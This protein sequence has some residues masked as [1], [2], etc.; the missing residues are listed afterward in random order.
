VLTAEKE[1][2][3]VRLWGIDAPE[4][5]QDFG[6]ASREALSDLVAGKTVTVEV[7]SKDRYGRNV[8]VVTLDDVDANLAQ[9][10]NGWA[11]WYREYA[12]RAEHLERAET[13]ARGAKKGLWRGED[14]VAPW[15]WRKREK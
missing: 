8:G 6:R 4:L 5:K 7:K 2:V 10:A 12:K 14:P 9:V 3:K 11:W 13:A 1:Q 15:D